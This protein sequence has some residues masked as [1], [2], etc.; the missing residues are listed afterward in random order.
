MFFKS[1]KIETS[2]WFHKQASMHFYSFNLI[3][4]RLDRKLIWG[5]GVKAFALWSP[6]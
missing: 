5:W 2:Y 4:V 1:L 6:P 3:R